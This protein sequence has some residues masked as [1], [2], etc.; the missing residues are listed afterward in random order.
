MLPHL[1]TEEQQ[2]LVRV[3]AANGISQKVIAQNL[4]ITQPTLNKYYRAELRDAHGRVEAAMGAAIVKAA[5]NGNWSA[6][7]YWLLVNAKDPRWRDAQKL[8]KEEDAAMAEALAREEP[9]RFYMPS[10][11]R[12]KPIMDDDD[13]PTIE[14]TVSD[15]A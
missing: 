7:K 6:A 15:A 3:L 8:M 14:G 2:Q 9:V 12:D 5:L 13:P 11:G 1:V 4:N 10:N